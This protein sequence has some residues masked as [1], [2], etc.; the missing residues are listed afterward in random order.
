MYSFDHAEQL[1]TFL[2]SLG[3]G[4]LLGVVY[5][6]LRCIRLSVSKGKA[7]VFVFDILYFLIFGFA[8]FLFILA[9]NYGEVRFFIIFGEC[10]GALFYYFSFGLAAIKISD[11]VVRAFRFIIKLIFKAVSA[12]FILVFRVFRKIFRLLGAFI[13]KIQKFF[14]NHQKNSCQNSKD[15]YII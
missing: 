4:F 11:A 5:D 14:Q 15:V 1:N 10:I 9:A 13:R 2:M 3:A 6:I 7:A 12:P 8:S